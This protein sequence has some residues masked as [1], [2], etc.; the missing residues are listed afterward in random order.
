QGGA[1][2]LQ[3]AADLF[4]LLFDVPHGLALRGG[5]LVTTDAGRGHGSDLDVLRA[6]LEGAVHSRRRLVS[7]RAPRS[8]VPG[9]AASSLVTRV[10]AEHLAALAGTAAPS[11][12]AVGDRG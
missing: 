2:L 9:Q 7:H 8:R 11:L 3:Q 5:R 10:R 12:P 6:W 1:G 4:R